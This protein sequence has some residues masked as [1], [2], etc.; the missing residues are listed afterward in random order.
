MCLF[1]RFVRLDIHSPTFSISHK[2]PSASSPPLFSYILILRSKVLYT[3]KMTVSPHHPIPSHELTLTGTN[4][5]PNP[6]PNLPQRIPRSLPPPQRNGPSNLRNLPATHLPNAGQNPRR[7][8]VAPRRCY[9][10]DACESGCFW[11]V[12]SFVGFGLRC[13]R[14]SILVINLDKLC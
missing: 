11:G 9:R 14:H 2:Y 1:V 5:T 6:P 12:V 4:P 13:V 10:G 3:A 8:A 7:R